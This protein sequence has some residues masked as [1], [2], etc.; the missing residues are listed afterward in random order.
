M[1]CSQMIK[2]FILPIDLAIVN[3]VRRW[4]RLVRIL[5]IVVYVACVS[6]RGMEGT[7]RTKFSYIWLLSSIPAATQVGNHLNFYHSL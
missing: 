2:H 3:D 6:L 7:K 5:A 4:E 1:V